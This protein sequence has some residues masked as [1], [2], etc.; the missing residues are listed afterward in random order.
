MIQSQLDSSSGFPTHTLA[1]LRWGKPGVPPQG[2][3][4]RGG[5]GELEFLFAIFG[6]FN[7]VS[8]LDGFVN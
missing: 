1:S 5:F 3:S 4:S 8:V 2:H 7:Y 6:F